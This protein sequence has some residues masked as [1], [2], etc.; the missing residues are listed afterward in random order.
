MIRLMNQAETD[1]QAFAPQASDVDEILAEHAEELVR[2]AGPRSEEVFRE[3]RRLA[4][5]RLPQ[6]RTARALAGYIVGAIVDVRAAGLPEACRQAKPG[7][8]DELWG[9]LEP[10]LKRVIRARSLASARQMDALLQAVRN[11]IFKGMASFSPER[12]SFY[13]WARTV[14]ANTAAGFT[15]E[16]LAA[17][18]PLVWDRKQGRE[19][20]PTPTLPFRYHS[21]EPPVAAREELMELALG[22]DPH[23]VLTFLL[24][25]YLRLPQ[26]EIVDRF[27]AATLDSLAE[28]VVALGV[29]ERERKYLQS[30]V[31]RLRPTL[32][33]DAP[34]GGA[35]G[36][37]RLCDL[38]DPA[39]PEG[40]VKNWSAAPHRSAVASVIQQAKRFL[41]SVCEL[42]HAA[43]YE[44]PAFFWRRFL[45]RSVTELIPWFGRGIESVAD[46]FQRDC[47]SID[48]LT[49]SQVR[50]AITPW[51]EQ[52]RHFSPRPLGAYYPGATPAQ[53]LEKARMKVEVLV[54]ERAANWGCA[55]Y[56]Y[57][58]GCFTRGTDPG[59]VDK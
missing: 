57:L 11:A 41:R 2:S 18:D 43:A 56:A 32:A 46:D 3:V 5:E 13:A 59:E 47:A 58:R 38:W 20:R 8:F 33:G 31:D 49:E 15:P 10:Y 42:K 21:P 55:A 48:R 4:L 53:D 17:A 7:A 39:E 1:P 26:G 16:A 29:N 23:E 44:K 24:N 19:E 51:R 50:W 27:G 37:R 45:R 28:T 40:S 54:E 34:G 52:A 30:I 9:I 12:G 22:H 6:V 35:W 36:E 14:A 25:R